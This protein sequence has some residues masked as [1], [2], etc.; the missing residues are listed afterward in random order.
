MKNVKKFLA[1][2]LVGVFSAGAV[3][4]ANA[5][6]FD[7]SW[8]AAQNPDVVAVYG[9]SA[10]ALKAHYDRHGRTEYRMS[11]ENDVEAQLHKLFDLEEYKAMYPDVVIVL[12]NN[13]DAIFQHY[14]M[15]GLLEG[16][17][18]SERVSQEAALEL[19]RV[20]TQALADAGLN[21]KPGSADLLKVLQGNVTSKSSAVQAA[22]TQ[23]QAV[24]KEAVKT[25]IVADATAPASSSDSGSSDDSSSSDNSGNQGSSNTGNTGSNTGNTG[26]NTGSADSTGDQNTGNSGGNSS[27]ADSTGDQNTGNSGGNSG[28]ADSTG[29]Q[30]AD[31]TGDQ[32]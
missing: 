21:A 28:S 16:R 2:A 24:V 9:N 13:P 3:L 23:V 15:F 22:L 14:L 32:D 4:T 1:L 5:A 17:R 8:Y 11:S 31:S 12:R 27:S 6:T 7:A 19:K 29:D 10:E 20:V 30:N 26:S 18:P 25:T